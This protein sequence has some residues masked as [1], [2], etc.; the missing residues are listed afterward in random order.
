MCFEVKKVTRNAHNM[1]FFVFLGSYGTIEFSLVHDEAN[2]LLVV[3]IAKAKVS[4]A[5][6]QREYK[7][8]QSNIFSSS[9]L[10]TENQRN[11]YKWLVRFLLQSYNRSGRWK[12]ECLISFILLEL[13]WK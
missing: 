2:R 9:L 6:V 12:G 3:N 10:S 5:K 8:S 13:I 7:V 11:G 1:F 4:N